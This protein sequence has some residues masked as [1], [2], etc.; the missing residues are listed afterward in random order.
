MKPILSNHPE[1]MYNVAARS[2]CSSNA[3][4]GDLNS[5]MM[6]SSMAETSLSFVA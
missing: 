1:T 4:V 3:P 6:A 5:T 2:R